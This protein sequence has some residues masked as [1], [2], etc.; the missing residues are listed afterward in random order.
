MISGRFWE[1]ILVLAS[2]LLGYF[3][4]IELA[5]YIEGLW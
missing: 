2:F 4:L 5:N 1:A 3:A